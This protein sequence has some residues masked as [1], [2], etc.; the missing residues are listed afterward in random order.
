MFS[1]KFSGN[2]FLSRYPSWGKLAWGCS[3]S[4]SEE[5]LVSEA[6]VVFR[7]Y[8][9][10]RLVE[11]TPERTVRT[12]KALGADIIVPLD[13]L[14]PY[15]IDRADLKRSVYLSHRWEGEYM[16]PPRREERRTD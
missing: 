14:P 12:Q 8:R 7:S 3:S 16:Q 9:D 2:Q 15:H 4:D 10:G 13:E 5:V 1:R 11:L 6:G